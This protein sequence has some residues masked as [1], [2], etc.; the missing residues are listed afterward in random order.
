MAQLLRPCCVSWKVARSI[1]DGVIGIF[2]L[3]NPSGCTYGPGI[4]SAF[5]IN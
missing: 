1:P 2:Y 3:H 4:D 5:N